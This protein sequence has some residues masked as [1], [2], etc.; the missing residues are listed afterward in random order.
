MSIIR[1]RLH[2]LELIPKEKFP[3]IKVGFYLSQRKSYLHVGLDQ[4]LTSLECYKEFKE[5][6]INFSLLIWMTRILK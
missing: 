1:K 2:I 5:K 4:S 6:Y 3:N